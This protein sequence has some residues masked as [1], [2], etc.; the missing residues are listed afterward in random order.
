MKSATRTANGD[1]IFGVVMAGVSLLVFLIA[2][3]QVAN[4]TSASSTI[5]KTGEEG[6]AYLVDGAV[7]EVVREEKGRCC[8]AAASALVVDDVFVAEV[9]V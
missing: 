4:E 1:A 9:T 6:K 7:A 8:A 3:A 5:K 2:L